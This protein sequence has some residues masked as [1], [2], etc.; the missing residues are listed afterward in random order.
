[1]HKEVKPLQA[2]LFFYLY[3]CILILLDALMDSWFA[4]FR[5]FKIINFA[6]DYEYQIGVTLPCHH[7][8]KFHQ[9]EYVLLE[10]KWNIFDGVFHAVSFFHIS[11]II[12]HYWLWRYFTE[13]N[14][15]KNS[16]ML[17][18]A[19]WYMLFGYAS[20]KDRTEINQLV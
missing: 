5:L 13:H 2:L 18:R 3:T 16:H 1:M 14:G 19:V 8:Q 11:D 15:G 20:G 6:V 10:E 17:F 7:I 9:I 12:D 4:Q